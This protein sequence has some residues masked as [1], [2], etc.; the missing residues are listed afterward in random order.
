MGKKSFLIGCTMRIGIYEA[1]RDSMIMFTRAMPWAFKAC[2]LGA[3]TTQAFSGTATNAR[4]E[5]V[6]VGVCFLTLASVLPSIVSCVVDRTKTTA[7]IVHSALFL[8]CIHAAVLALETWHWQQYRVAVTQTC[9]LHLLWSQWRTLTHNKHVLIYQGPVQC[10]LVATAILSWSVCALMMPRF[11]VEIVG[12]VGL[13]FVG[14]VVGVAV[15][16]VAAVL[17]GVG[18]M[19]E[20]CLADKTS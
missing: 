8:L 19:A 12:L 3:V 1:R 6:L 13:M 4:Q 7:Y 14:E 17:V 16:L 5:Y 18:D 2:T 9:L 11:P 10:M 20:T 15:S